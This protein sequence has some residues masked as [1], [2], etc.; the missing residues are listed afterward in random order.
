D[1]PRWD[2]APLEGRTILLHAEQGLGDTVQFAR[3]ATPVKARGGTVVL[4]CQ[5]ALAPL[6]SGCPGV[7]R[8]VPRGE[9]LPPFDVH[10]PLLSLPALLGTTLETVPAD[11]PYLLARGELVERWR[12]RLGPAEGLRVGIAWQGNPDYPNDRYRSVPLSAFA[13]LAAVEGVRLYS[14]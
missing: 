3:Y 10:A 6:L 8:L 5:G 1:R 7:D 2:G 13:P 12:E 9:P 11:V 4:Q 14:L